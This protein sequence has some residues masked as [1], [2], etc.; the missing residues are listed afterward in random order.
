MT[1]FKLP[2]GSTSLASFIASDVA[3]S[4]FAGDIANMMQLGYKKEKSTSKYEIEQEKPLKCRYYDYEYNF[5]VL[6]YMTEKGIG[7]L[8]YVHD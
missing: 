2:V 6:V 8:T 3:I 1:Y 4:W 7:F 5:W